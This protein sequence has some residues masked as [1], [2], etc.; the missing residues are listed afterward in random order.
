LNFSLLN[1]LF[2]DFSLPTGSAKHRH[3]QD[4]VDHFRSIFSH[5]PAL[6]DQNAPLFRQSSMSPTPQ[7]SSPVLD[8]LL[9]FSCSQFEEHGIQN[10]ETSLYF[11]NK[12]LQG[13]IKL[14]DNLWEGNAEEIL[15]TIMLL[16]YYEI[17]SAPLFH[18]SI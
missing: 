2:P 9:A 10:E 13:L 3:R 18:H 11:H 6:Q 1:T 5:L 12:A 16:V 14:L 17:V 7:A 8:I 15:S 4:L